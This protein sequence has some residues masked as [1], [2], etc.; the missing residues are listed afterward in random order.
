MR[1]NDSYTHDLE[2][3]VR[4]A[5]L[6]KSPEARRLLREGERRRAH[7]AEPARR[8]PKRRSPT[9]PSRRS[10]DGI[11]SRQRRST[12]RR[13][14]SAARERA[15]ISLGGSSS[16]ASKRSKSPRKAPFRSMKRKTGLL[17]LCRSMASFAPTCNDVTASGA[18][19]T[20][21]LCPVPVVKRP[22]PDGSGGPI[23]EPRQL[24]TVRSGG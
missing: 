19:S 2:Q 15:G 17:P 14:R 9:S 16:Q 7:P 12:C 8:A 20:E 4:V 24:F 11:R 18:I 1:V 10:D 23:R 6:A 21:R 22:T 3:L 13:S 5:E